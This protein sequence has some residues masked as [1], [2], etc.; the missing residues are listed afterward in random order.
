V[1]W[2]IHEPGDDL[3]PIDYYEYLK[4]KEWKEKSAQA[5]YRAGLT[6]ELCGRHQNEL[7]D[8][9]LEA[10]HVS[11]VRLGYEEPEDL[12]VLCR[13]CHRKI[14]KDK[15]TIKEAKEIYRKVVLWRD[16]RDRESDPFSF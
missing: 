3:P 11:Y 13:D 12:V 6:C 9:E 7:V 14:H 15:V 4:T 5:K 10:H 16:K 1:E 8:S 2:D